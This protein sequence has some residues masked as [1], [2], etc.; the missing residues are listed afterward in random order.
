MTRLTEFLKDKGV[1]VIDLQCSPE[2]SEPIWKRLGFLEFPDPPENYGPDLRGN[3]KLYTILVEHLQASPVQSAEETIELWNYESYTSNDNSPPAYIWNLEFIEGTRR[4][5]KPIIQPGYRGW[6]IRWKAND[7]IKQDN[8]VK[9]FMKE[10]E[11]GTFV[12]IDELTL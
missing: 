2:T 7:T 11:F 3:K 6:R 9:R 8:Q 12:I 1:Y 5:V 4:L 10:I